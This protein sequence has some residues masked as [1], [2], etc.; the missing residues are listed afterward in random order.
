M[1]TADGNQSE[2]LPEIEIDPIE[3]QEFA[4]L[5]KTNRT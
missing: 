1:I 3:D 4:V 5:G 2:V